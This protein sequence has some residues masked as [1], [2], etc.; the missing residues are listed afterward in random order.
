MSATP[1][2][3]SA[4]VSAGSHLMLA[5]ISDIAGEET[6]GKVQ[7][8][9]GYSPSARRYG[10]MHADPAAPRYVKDRR[11]E[12]LQEGPE[13]LKSLDDNKIESDTKKGYHRTSQKLTRRGGTAIEHVR[14]R[15][16]RWKQGH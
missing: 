11:G 16:L 6:A 12:R 3:S 13:R 14:E 10:S 9:T 7:F 2:W 1:P 5:C 8:A 4:G 15:K